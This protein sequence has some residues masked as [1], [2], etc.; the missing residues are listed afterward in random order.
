FALL[1][2]SSLSLSPCLNPG[3]FPISVADLFHLIYLI[4]HTSRT[5]MF[6]SHARPLLDEAGWA[7]ARRRA[8]MIWQRLCKTFLAGLVAVAAAGSSVAGDGCSTP[9][10]PA[11]CKVTCVEWVPEQYQT[12]RTT[13][14]TEC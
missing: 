1:Q 2:D 10:A 14:K 11:T 7:D 12:T 8:P 5:G 3:Y 13:Y 6:P 9:C 4:L